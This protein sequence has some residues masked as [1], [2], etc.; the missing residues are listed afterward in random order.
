MPCQINKTIVHY[1]LGTVTSSVMGF[2]T[3]LCSL[4]IQYQVWISFFGV[5]LKST[6]KEVGIPIRVMPLLHQRAN[7]AWQVDTVAFKIH[8]CLRLLSF[9]LWQP[10]WH[11]LPQGTLGS[12]EGVSNLVLA[13]PTSF[14]PR[15]VA[16]SATW[17]YHLVQ[18]NNDNSLCCFQGLWIFSDSCMEISHT[19]YWDFCLSTHGCWD[20]HCPH[21]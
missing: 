21:V 8:C 10:A 14:L 11:L 2:W 18:V 20:W 19:W 17:S 15:C 13:L 4:I 9:L 16:S 12:R 6:Q 3:N 5:S 7:L 1:S